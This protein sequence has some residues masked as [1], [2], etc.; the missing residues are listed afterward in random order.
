MLKN[1]SDNS[2]PKKDIGHNRYRLPIEAE[3]EY[4]TRASTTTAYSFGDNIS[5]L[6]RYAW[7]GEDFARGGTHS[8]G[9]KLPNPWGLYDV[10]GNAWEW[11]QDWY[12]E[13][14]LYTKPV[15]RPHRTSQWQSARRAG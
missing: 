13:I 10:H 14:L 4:A 2:T 8:I 9:Q 11:V 6:G 5:D 1:S 12:N 15:Y 7:Y 3:W